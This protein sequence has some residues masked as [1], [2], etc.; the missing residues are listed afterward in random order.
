MAGNLQFQLKKLIQERVKSGQ[1][2]LRGTAVSVP[3]L[4][5]V[6]GN[7]VWVVDVMIRQ[8][9]ELLK[10]VPIAENNRQIRNFVNDGTPVEVHRSNMGQFYISG[11]SDLE[12]GQV[13][14]KT[15]S[16]ENLGI[17][18]TRGWK[19]NT[20]SG[21]LETGN[22][23]TVTPATEA[24]ITYSYIFEVIPLGELDFGVTPLGAKRAIRTP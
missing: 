14:K 17:A 22:S 16:P 13:N 7:P 19:R 10:N 11:L 6:N 18:F 4:Q 3:S 12:S 24:T 2:K 21:N 23:N 15:Y 1:Q 20:E 8:D 5:T 9:E